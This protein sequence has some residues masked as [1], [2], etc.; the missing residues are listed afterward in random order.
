MSDLQVPEGAYKRRIQIL[1]LEISQIDER[2]EL[3]RSP[4]L[5]RITSILFDHFF[6]SDCSKETQRKRESSR[7]HR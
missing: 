7:H 4:L 2:K 1:E 3:V 5:K 6:L